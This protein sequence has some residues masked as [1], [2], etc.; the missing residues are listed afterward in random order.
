MQKKKF[1]EAVARQFSGLKV[2]EDDV[3]HVVLKLGFNVTPI[4]LIVK[5][6]ANFKAA[7]W[8]VTRAKIPPLNI[9][10]FPKMCYYN[11]IHHSMITKITPTS[12]I[13]LSISKAPK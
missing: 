4:Y 1:S 2:K 11:N 7:N 3:A 9:D 10:L 6:L 8:P 12:I 5:P 13:I